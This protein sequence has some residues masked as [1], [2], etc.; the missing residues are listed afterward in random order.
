MNFTFRSIE[1]PRMSEREPH[2]RILWSKHKTNS[3]LV[4]Y[5]MDTEPVVLWEKMLHA[6]SELVYDLE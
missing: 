2:K 6:R 1:R 5:V 4:S 3:G